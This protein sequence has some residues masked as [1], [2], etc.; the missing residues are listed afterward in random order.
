MMNMRTIAKKWIVLLA[1]AFSC[2]GYA[3]TPVTATAGMSDLNTLLSPHRA[4]APGQ[5]A[6]PLPDGSWL[7]T[8]GQGSAG[9]ASAAATIVNPAGLSNTL[10]AQLLQPRSGHS[11]TLLPSGVVLILGGTD[12]NGNV[13]STAEQ[14]DPTTGVF[15]ALGNLGVI[16]RTGHSAT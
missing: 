10:V 4:T 14:Y 15:T 12:A 2:A 7:L 11:A 1:C 16:P 5:A 6:T 13:I 8:G 3:Q 9:S